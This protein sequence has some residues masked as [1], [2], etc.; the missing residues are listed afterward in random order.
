MGLTGPGFT[1]GRKS[2]IYGP[3]VKAFLAKHKPKFRQADKTNWKE[4]ERRMV[5]NTAVHE[6]WHAVCL[7]K[8]HNPVDSDSVMMLDPGKHVLAFG[9]ERLYFTKG[10]RQRLMQQFSWRG[11]R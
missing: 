1:E 9:T 11:G 8:S 3:D 7:S 2:Y 10:H 4:I 6:V 5:T